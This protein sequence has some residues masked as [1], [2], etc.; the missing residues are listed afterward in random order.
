MQMNIF[1]AHEHTTGGCG[2]CMDLALLLMLGFQNAKYCTQSSKIEYW[3]I[4]LSKSQALIV[5]VRMWSME[6]RMA[7]VVDKFAKRLLVVG[8]CGQWLDC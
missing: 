8:L 4:N 1:H 2:S 6:H 3:M 5:I 7:K